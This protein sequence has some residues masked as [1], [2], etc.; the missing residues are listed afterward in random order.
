MQRGRRQLILWK[1]ETDS[2]LLHVCEAQLDGSW[3]DRD[4]SRVI[5][6]CLQDGYM[7]S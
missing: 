6:G 1:Q 4:V 5:H 3:L 7:P 2:F